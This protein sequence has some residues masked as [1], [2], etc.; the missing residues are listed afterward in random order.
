MYLKRT[1]FLIVG[2]SKSGYFAT[3]LLLS[4]GAECY[5]YEK[6][7]NGRAKKFID[8]LILTGATIINGENLQDAIERI[9]V[10][11]LSPGIAID[12][13]IPIM[14]R[15]L[16]KNIIGELELGYYFCP[17]T[18]IAITG[19]NGKTTTCSL[20]DFVLNKAKINSCLAG[21][22]GIPLCSQCENA[23][24]YQVAVTEVSSYQL[25]TIA[26]FTPHIACVLNVSPDH[27]SRHYNMDNYLYLKSRILKNLRESEFAV[28]NWDDE[29]IREF[30]INTRAQCVYFSLTEEIDGAFYKEGAIYWKGELIINAEEIALKG[31]HNLQNVLACVCICKLM[32]VEKEII[33]EGLEQ[34]K[35]VKHRMQIITEKKGV[36][37]INDSKATNPDSTLSAISSMESSFILL[38]GGQEKGEGYENLFDKISKC[39]KIKEVIIFGESR[40]KLYKIASQKQVKRISL[41]SCFDSAVKF[42]FEIAKK[43]ESLLL[44]PACASFDEFS[45]FEERGERFI[46]LVEEK[47]ENKKC[48]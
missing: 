11:V 22:I 1:K 7:Q 15:R 36:T 9:D 38:I 8:E 25:E 29:R 31:G 28:L 23:Q 5:I 12:S 2:I 18:I 4:K 14:A 19:T 46:E 33:K 34:F 24:N 44:S 26:K 21:N 13:E 47:T 40:E 39:E 27:L 6:D 35:G 32:G 20:V 43:G 16:K 41:T 45:G 3:K 30:S 10:V 48:V 42:G 37:F 17:Q